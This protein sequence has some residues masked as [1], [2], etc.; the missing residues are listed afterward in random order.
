V[1]LALGV[2]VTAGAAVRVAFVGPPIRYDEAFTFLQYAS[3]PWRTIVSD[4]GFANNHILH[5][6]EVHLAWRL[7]GDAPEV[8]RI[9]ALVAGVLLVPAVYVL[10]RLVYD[11]AAALWGAALVAGSS[12]L[13]Q[14][15]VN[16]RGYS[17]GMLMVVVAVAAATWAART[18]ATWAW[19][20]LGVS[21]VLAVYSIPTMAGGIA[22]AFVWC[23]VV[24]WGTPELRDRM[25]WMLASGVAATVVGALLYLPTRGDAGWS[26]ASSFGVRGSGEKVGLVE[27]IWDQWIDGL[28]W[29]VYVLLAAAFVVGVVVHRRLARDPV[30]LGV[31][32]IVV[33]LVAGIVLPQSPLPRTY[34]FLLPFLLLTAGAGLAWAIAHVSARPMVNAGAAAAACV[35]L[36][37]AF[38]F[39]GN[40]ALTID[41]PRS[42]DGIGALIEPGR[43][44]MSSLVTSDPVSFDLRKHGLP[45]PAY[46]MDQIGA[47]ARSVVL[48]VAP[49]DDP[50]VDEVMAGIGLTPAPGT[51]PRLLR[52][53]RWL[54]SHEVEPGR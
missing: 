5:T 18:G 48:V 47:E 41:P 14:Y 36:S 25:K 31:V 23:V 29:P 54:D 13:I 28:P 15:S 7:L 8:L 17:T 12:V 9:P 10:G 49:A 38:G 16:A 39:R 19:V 3:Q 11:R 52:D 22:V 46:A 50:P 45:P 32:A 44:F 24:A 51:E 53:T 26:A 20:L 6:L 4:Y 43:P 40:D 37:L 42:D 34:L 27:R 2:I 35:A 33:T 21:S 30:P 1:K